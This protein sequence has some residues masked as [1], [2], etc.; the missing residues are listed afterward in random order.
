[1]DPNTDEVLE[2]QEDEDK[3]NASEPTDVHVID[4]SDPNFDELEE[5]FEITH[6]SKTSIDESTLPTPDQEIFLDDEQPTSESIEGDDDPEITKSIPQDVVNEFEHALDNHAHKEIISHS[7]SEGV[8]LFEI[9]TVDGTKL[10]IPYSVLKQNHPYDC[11]KHT[12]SHV[13]EGRR[14]GLKPHNTWASSFLKQHKRNFRRL[15]ACWGFT[16]PKFAV[17]PKRSSGKVI[18]R[19]KVKT[20]VKERF[21]INTPV[22]QEKRHS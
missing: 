13:I 11:A 17:T 20:P 4:P 10:P 8:L 2:P 15:H 16:H 14:S 9:L 5:A 19:K 12:S 3:P 21:G 1:M 22:A 18:L 7:I 6:I